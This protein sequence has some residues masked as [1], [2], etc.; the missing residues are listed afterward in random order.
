MLQKLNLVVKLAVVMIL[1]PLFSSVV[2]AQGVE[3][4]HHKTA[5]G[6]HGMAV[7]TDG[8][9]FYASH[10]PLANSIHAH[11]VIFSFTLAPTTASKLRQMLAQNT[12]I[13][14]NPERF[15]LMELMSGK[16][17]SFK[18]S[19]VEGHFERGGKTALTEVVINVSEML[20][21]AD[22]PTNTNKNGQFFLLK[23]A[24][25]AGLLIHRIVESPSFDQIVQVTILSDPPATK[26]NLPVPLLTITSGQKIEMSKPE[27]KRVEGYVIKLG[28]PLYLETRDFQ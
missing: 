25:S 5:V 6:I 2:S 9:K 4:K 8:S 22:L 7:F 11:Q 13:S 21:T 20:L 1:I 16:L 27:I 26:T 28:S 23:T 19:L 10:M 15:D 3:H 12:L 24:E 18:G 17:T 14:L